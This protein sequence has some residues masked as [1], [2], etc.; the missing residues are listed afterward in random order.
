[1]FPETKSCA[2]IQYLNVKDAQNAFNNLSYAKFKHL[3][4][5]LEWAPINLFNGNDNDND[6]DNDNNNNNKNH[7]IVEMG[8]RKR[9]YIEMDESEEKTKVIVKNIPFETEKKELEKLFGIYGKIKAL[10]LPK[11]YG[12]GHRG[13]C[14]IEFDTNKEA[15]NAFNA[16]SSS[17]FYGRHLVIEWVKNHETNHNKRPRFT[18]K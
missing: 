6:N 16:L 3:P 18:M 15:L 5:F 13:F 10:R 12:G 7:D 2:I 17:H 9:K 11:K 1:M 4:L 8:K 14:F